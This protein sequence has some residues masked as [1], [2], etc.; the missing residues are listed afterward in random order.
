MREVCARLSAC[1]VSDL[2]LKY[3]WG[4]G[5][6]RWGEIDV[7]VSLVG[8]VNSDERLLTS[9]NPPADP[10]LPQDQG[11]ANDVGQYPQVPATTDSS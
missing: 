1:V 11:V 10:R 9:L 2:A 5:S 3:G 4:Q 6:S 7:A 8:N